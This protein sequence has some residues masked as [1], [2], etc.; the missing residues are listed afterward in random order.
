M[1]DWGKDWKTFAI[2]YW[3]IFSKTEWASKNTK[4]SAVTC[5]LN[6]SPLPKFTAC[7][8]L[9][10]MKLLPSPVSGTS[11]GVYV[12]PTVLQEHNHILLSRQLKKVKKANGEIIGVNVVRILLIS[13]AALKRQAEWDCWLVGL[14]CVFRIFA[15][16][17]PPSLPPSSLVYYRFMKRSL[18]RSRT[19]ASGSVMIRGLERT[20]CIRSSVTLAVQM[21]SRACTRTWLPGIVLASARFTY[22]FFFYTCLKCGSLK[23]FL[24]ID[25][26]CGR[27]WEDRWYPSSLY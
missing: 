1:I 19:L 4:S 18:W 13:L 16:F 7:A 2:S 9:R 11:W 23:P 22:V 20:T 24:S 14:S 8:F 15:F 3:Q 6:R 5:P 25:P 26:P 17:H 12:I 21:L 27:D 10:L